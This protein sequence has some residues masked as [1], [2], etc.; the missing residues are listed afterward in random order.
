[1]T[2]IDI[3]KYTGC[4]LGAA[5]GDALGTPFIGLSPE[6]TKASGSAGTFLPAREAFSYLIPVGELG[7]SEVS[8][9]LLAGQWTEDVQLML[10]LAN[11]LIEE[12]GILIPEAWAHSLVRWL[13]SEPR[14]FGVSTVQAALQ[15]RTGG[16]LWDEAADPEGGGCGPA[17]RVAPIAL[18]F[19]ADANQRR[20]AALTQAEVTHEDPDAHAAALAV[21]EA[22]ALVLPVTSAALSHWDGSAFLT[23]LHSRVSAASPHYTAFSR[24]LLL[25]RTLLEDD[26]DLP[27]AVRVLGTTGWSREAVPC[28]LFCVA[29]SPLHFESLLTEVITYTTSTTEAIGCLVGAIAGA[30]HGI[31]AIPM[32]WRA[33]V[34]EAA[35]ITELA[36]ALYALTQ[37]AYV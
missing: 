21:A 22:I 12:G 3:R 34:E 5:I 20:Q 23:E 32:H 10:A 37:P 25:A 14:S 29:H 24:C 26:V 4:L 28:A 13:N 18:V 15:L 35:P 6:Q 36:R 30:L 1:M 7:E 17:A 27:N 2:P 11:T 9:R 8:E 16:V 33:G 31:E 19:P